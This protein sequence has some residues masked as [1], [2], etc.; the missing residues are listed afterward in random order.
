MYVSEVY[1]EESIFGTKTI[2]VDLDKFASGKADKLLIVG[3]S[4]SGKTV[5][6]HYLEKIY[7]VPVT[8]LD[9][10]TF[11]IYKTMTDDDMSKKQNMRKLNGM[12]NKCILPHLKSKKRTIIEGGAIP[13]TYLEIKESR[14]L[15][16]KHPTIFVG[17]SLATSIKRATWRHMTK[18]L[19]PWM[20]RMIK[21]YSVN[22]K[23]IKPGLKKFRHDRI[24]Y[25][26]ADV[27]PFNL[28]KI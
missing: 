23:Y 27:Q 20:K 2:S 7:G 4:G 19:D 28:P 25:R 10:C 5:L 18:N 14:S 22:V 24:E 13:Q 17:T 8:H 15:I 1:L 12:Y 16:I 26:S 9:P 3:L 6:A 11:P 21:Y